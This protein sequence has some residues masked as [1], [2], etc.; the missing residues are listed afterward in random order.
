MAPAAISRSGANSAI[1]GRILNDIGRPTGLGRRNCLRI[2]FLSQESFELSE[3]RHP[4]MEIQSVDRP[5]AE[6]RQGCRLR[7]GPKSPQYAVM[8]IT[9]AACRLA[10]GPPNG[11]SG[12]KYAR[13]VMGSPYAP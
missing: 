6:H 13:P 8:P 9:D 3:I 10:L 1:R 12:L 11:N 7:A 2:I 4:C 5:A